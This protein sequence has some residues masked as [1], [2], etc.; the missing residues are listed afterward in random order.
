M[1]VK[2]DRDAVG[3]A[4]DDRVLVHVEES[5]H[6]GQGAAELR[7]RDS[8][9]D[10]CGRLINPVARC[11]DEVAQQ[12]PDLLVGKR[13]PMSALSLLGKAGRGDYPACDVVLAPDFDDLIEWR[14]LS[15]VDTSGYA[16]LRKPQVAA[17]MQNFGLREIQCLRDTRPSHLPVL[18]AL[19]CHVDR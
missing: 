5:L 19:P 6:H 7:D 13:D 12:R 1:H 9:G 18:K 4:A 3:V 16:N 2:A 8:K 14:I 11:L 15:T 17:A 10:S